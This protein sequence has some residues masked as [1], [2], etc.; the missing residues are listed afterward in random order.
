MRENYFKIDL[1]Y[2]TTHYRISDEMKYAIWCFL[3]DEGKGQ[4]LE[5]LYRMYLDHKG[6]DETLRSKLN[7]KIERD[8]YREMIRQLYEIPDIVDNPPGYSSVNRKNWYFFPKTFTEGGFYNQGVILNIPL[9]LD[10]SKTRHRPL[11]QKIFT[12]IFLQS[13]YPYD[14]VQFQCSSFR[15][16]DQFWLFLELAYSDFPNHPRKEVLAKWMASKRNS[17]VD[18]E[19]P[20]SF[21]AVFRV[22]E[23]YD[24]VISQLSKLEHG[25]TFDQNGNFTRRGKGNESYCETLLS[26][27]ERRGFFKP[28]LSFQGSAQNEFKIDFIRRNFGVIISKKSSTTGRTN[29]KHEASLAFLKAPS[30]SRG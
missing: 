18:P 26:V 6:N 10:Y 9:S 3:C 27:L 19:L 21:R 30:T 25:K 5:E 20:L 13:E 4:Y 7:G 15:N 24:Y 11:F 22:P 12:E 28:S 1:F 14:F 8:L 16:V 23:F 29:E 17:F 2:F